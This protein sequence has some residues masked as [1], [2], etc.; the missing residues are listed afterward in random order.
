ML[1][2]QVWGMA[3][4]DAI[5]RADI[6]LFNKD[7]NNKIQQQE[8]MYMDIS[9]VPFLFIKTNGYLLYTLSIISIIVY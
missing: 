6:H 8:Q 1:F 4:S 5:F 9:F 3:I 2:P 7:N